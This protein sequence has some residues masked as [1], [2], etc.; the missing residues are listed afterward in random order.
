MMIEE[1][2][3]LLEQGKGCFVPLECLDV[4]ND[5][6]LINEYGDIYSTVRHRIL[7]KCVDKDGYYYTTLQNSNSERYCYRLATLVIMTF[8]GDPPQDMTDPTVDHI[9]SNRINN[10]FK[11]LRWLDRGVNSS[12]RKHINPNRDSKGRFC[13]GTK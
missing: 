4:K 10:H 3:E 8:K 5:L 13:T 12:I 9:D 1:C 11:N 2:V 6:Y 7:A